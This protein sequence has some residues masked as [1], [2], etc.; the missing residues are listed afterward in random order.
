MDISKANS[1]SLDKFNQDYFAEPN[2]DKKGFL[3]DIDDE[4]PTQQTTQQ[5]Q[6][7]TEVSSDDQKKVDGALEPLVSQVPDLKEYLATPF[8]LGKFDKPHEM[9]F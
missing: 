6:E 9:R 7:E 1:L 8:S 2:K 3:D 4:D 5:Q